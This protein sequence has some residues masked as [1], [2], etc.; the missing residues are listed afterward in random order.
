[1]TLQALIPLPALVMTVAALM[2]SA[3]AANAIPMTFTADLSG[4]NELPNR[5]PSPGTGLATVVL[6]PTAKRYKS[7]QRLAA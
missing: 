4:A 3:P 6:D 2:L 5:V 1:M 7:L